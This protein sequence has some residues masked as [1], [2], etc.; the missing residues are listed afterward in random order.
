M[1]T[2]RWMVVEARGGGPVSRGEE[3]G[4]EAAWGPV[5]DRAGISS[6]WT[7][8]LEQGYLHKTAWKTGLSGGPRECP[9]HTFHVWI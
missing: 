2:K 7:E 1:Q 8:H 9:T 4:Q 3:P 6:D 5:S